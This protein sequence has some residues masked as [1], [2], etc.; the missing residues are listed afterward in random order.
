MSEWAACLLRCEVLLRGLGMLRCAR[1]SGQACR[2]CRQGAAVQLPCLEMQAR[3]GSW[4]WQGRMA[5]LR[6][7]GPGLLT[8]D[9]RRTSVADGAPAPLK[10]KPCLPGAEPGVCCADPVDAAQAYLPAGRD[11]AVSGVVPLGQMVV[12]TR[13]LLFFE[14]LLFGPLVTVYCSV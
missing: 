8:C 12:S 2:R 1:F 7:S 4:G 13:S 10:N 14:T 3:C 11:A 6:R 9:F 5:F